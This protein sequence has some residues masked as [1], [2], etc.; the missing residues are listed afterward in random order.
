[1]VV[2]FEGD[3]GG[4]G[5]EGK[6]RWLSGDDAGVGKGPPVGW[7]REEKKESVIMREWEKERERNF[8]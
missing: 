5:R 8:R 1:M 7:E 4:D 2:E 3:R 6:G